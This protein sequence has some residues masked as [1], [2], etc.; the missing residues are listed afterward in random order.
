MSQFSDFTKSEY[1]NPLVFF[2][3]KITLKNRIGLAS[4]KNFPS[5]EAT[6]ACKIAF[7]RKI[8]TNSDG[9]DL[10]PKWE[11]VAKNSLCQ[12]FLIVKWC[13]TKR[14]VY[15]K[16]S[17]W[18]AAATWAEA[19]KASVNLIIQILGLFPA[20]RYGRKSCTRFGIV[21][22]NGKIVFESFRGNYL[23]Y[24]LGRFGMKGTTARY[25]R[26]QK[27]SAK[28]PFRETRPTVLRKQNYPIT[29]NSRVV[30]AYKMSHSP[31]GY[32]SPWI[33][34]GVCSTILCRGMSDILYHWTVALTHTAP[35]WSK[36]SLLMTPSQH[37]SSM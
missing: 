14:L 3:F 11:R 31:G 7:P 29:D 36:M 32:Y 12:P 35:D 15:E 1:G 10:I 24:P 16:T 26:V 34:T 5:N 28:L 17:L 6:T 25:G 2:F 33:G 18:P 30:P 20:A 27:I 22:R 19:Q 21:Y 8:L 9:L 37:I 23:F 13:T 4:T